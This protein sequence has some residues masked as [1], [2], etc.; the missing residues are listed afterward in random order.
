MR[1][2]EL[3]HKYNASLG[4]GWNSLCLCPNCAAKYRYGVKDVSDF[5]E[6][7]KSREVQAGDESYIK[8]RISLQD[9]EEEIRYTPKHFLA[10]K[11]AMEYFAK[12]ND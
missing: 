1:T 10:L 2:S 5:Y 8:I 12:T 7:V 3:D 6:Q 4:L 11:T 9:T